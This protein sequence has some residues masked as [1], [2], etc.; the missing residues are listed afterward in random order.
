MIAGGTI[1]ID[2]ART[3]AD[4]LMNLPFNGSANLVHS[5]EIGTAARMP[6]ADE[7][8]FGAPCWTVMLRPRK[9]DGPDT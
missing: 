5:I 1:Q 6:M 7:R 8:N 4:Q 9:L 2:L 3:E